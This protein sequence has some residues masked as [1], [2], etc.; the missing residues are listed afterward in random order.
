MQYPAESPARLLPDTK[1]AKN[2]KKAIFQKEP[3]KQLR[4]QKDQKTAPFDLQKSSPD[5]IRDEEEK[6]TTVHEL[7]VL[8]TEEMEH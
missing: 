2:N 6:T 4:A 3:S 8:H 7:L 1:P 5:L